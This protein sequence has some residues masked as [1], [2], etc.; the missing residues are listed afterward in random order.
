MIIEEELFTELLK[1]PDWY[2][3]LLHRVDGSIWIDLKAYS[4][5]G[6]YLPIGKGLDN[7]TKGY[8]FTQKLYDDK[9]R[10]KDNLIELELPKYEI[11][12][13][14]RLTR[15]PILYPIQ[16]AGVYNEAETPSIM[17]TRYIERYEPHYEKVRIN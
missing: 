6:H 3:L 1:D 5:L 4:D 7:Y 14:Q 9:Y 11:K 12:V 17:P 8:I 16:I 15:I 10:T 2:K 13:T